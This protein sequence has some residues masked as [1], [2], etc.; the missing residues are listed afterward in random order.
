LY[1]F[2]MSF[3]AHTLLSWQNEVRLLRW[4]GVGSAARVLDMG[5]GPGYVVAQLLRDFPSIR[6]VGVDNDGALLRLAACENA[7]WGGRAS[8]VE[9]QADAC[10]LATGSVQFVLA[11]YL[12]QHLA[13]PVGVAREARR[14]LAPGGR[15]AVID[16]DA[17]LWGL[18]DPAVAEPTPT[19][20][21]SDP[22][23][24]DAVDRFIGR[25]LWKIL[26][27]AGFEDV[28]VDAFVYHSDA[29]GLEPFAMRLDERI[30]AAPDAFVML[31]GLMASGVRG[32]DGGSEHP[33]VGP[34]S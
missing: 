20:P 31:A 9:A 19:P 3:R 26:R 13:D 5:C 27:A 21:A 2:A 23:T 28:H 10:P 25:R 18:T 12:F 29:L 24:A 7:L 22:A 30:T 1:F 33:P 17:G 11:R 6:V 32:I 15:L 14:M 8:F 16:V 34:S 4:L